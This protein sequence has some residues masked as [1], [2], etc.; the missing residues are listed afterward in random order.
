MMEDLNWELDVA[1]RRSLGQGAKMML[2]EALLVCSMTQDMKNRQP[3]QVFTFAAAIGILIN[4]LVSIMESSKETF[5]VPETVGDNI[6]QWNVEL[7]EFSDTALDQD[8]RHLLQLQLDFSMDLY[9]FFPPLVR[10][11]RPRLQ[12]SMM[13]RVTTMLILKLAYWDP[14]RD[15]KSVLLDFKTFLSTWAMLDL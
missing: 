3:K 8:F 10:V 9:P 7:S 14:V 1:R 11:I 5:I 4:D 2:M 6:F 12:G 15:M 13:L